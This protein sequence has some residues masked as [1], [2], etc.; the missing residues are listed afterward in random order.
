MKKVIA[1]LLAAVM[2]LSLGACGGSV[3][4]TDGNQA[5][6]KKN[7]TAVEITMDNW[8]EYLEFSS[9]YATY[10]T[11]SAFSDVSKEINGVSHDF[12]FGVKD[13]YFSRLDT[14]N[15][16]ITVRVS[17]DFGTQYGTFAD[18]YSSF[19]PN[20][21]FEVGKKNMELEND[22]VFKVTDH[23]KFAWIMSSAAAGASELKDGKLDK[24]LTNQK[25]INI[26]GTLYIT[27]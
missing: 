8:S 6:D 10:Y 19:D 1:M 24:W 2:C 9:T 27:E 5:D 4:S 11:D 15:S 20:G 16:A 13:E 22:D 21:K 26:T 23:G 25:V 17:A 14:V 12:Y 18:D 3:G 7:Y